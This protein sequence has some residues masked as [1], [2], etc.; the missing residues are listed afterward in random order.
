MKGNYLQHERQ[1]I[2]VVKPLVGW[3]YK[4]DRMYKG[5]LWGDD[6]PNWVTTE[7]KIIFMS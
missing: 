7:A 6:I 5:Y 2:E 1:L 3:M 4:I